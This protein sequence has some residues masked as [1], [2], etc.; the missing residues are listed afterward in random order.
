MPGHKV[1]RFFAK[2]M[3][4]R[5]YPEVDKAIDRPYAILGRRHRIIFHTP[6]EAYFMGSTATLDPKGGW[7]ALLHIWLDKKCSEDRKFK[8]E[9]ELASRQYEL[10]QKEMRKLEKQ[11]KKLRKRNS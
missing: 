8:K 6:L 2:I 9:M 5:A 1:H 11:L 4:G 10:Y 7:I 3:L